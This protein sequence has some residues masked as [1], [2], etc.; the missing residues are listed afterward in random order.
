[1]A[2]NFPHRAYRSRKF[3]K[4]GKW[5]LTFAPSKAC[6]DLPVDVPCGKC[7]GCM[8]ENAPNGVYASIMKPGC[9]M[10]TGF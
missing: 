5:P 10:T 2:C 8:K 3:G 1:M 6:T 4:D 7:E 9:M